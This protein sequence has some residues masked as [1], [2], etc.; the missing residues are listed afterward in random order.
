MSTVPSRLASPS[1]VG[2][3]VSVRS[4]AENIGFS[5][6]PPPRSRPVYVVKSPMLVAKIST[7]N[8]LHCWGTKPL[9]RST[10]SVPAS[11]AV[12]EMFRISKVPLPVPPSSTWNSPVASW[13]KSPTI[14]RTPAGRPGLV[15]PAVVTSTR[16]RPVPSIRPE[17]LMTSTSAEPPTS[18]VGPPAQDATGADRPGGGGVDVHPGRIGDL[19]QPIDTIQIVIDDGR[20]DREYCAGEHRGMSKAAAIDVELRGID[21]R[22]S[23]HGERAVD[24]DRAQAHVSASAAE[25][26]VV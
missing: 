19:D 6:N 16:I 25:R 2:M 26:R 15:T 21:R 23:G 14:R 12:P 8:S 1:I 20:V 4:V 24:T 18:A 9:I 11:V 5:D 3:T 7:L 17:A 22:G 13:V 10:S